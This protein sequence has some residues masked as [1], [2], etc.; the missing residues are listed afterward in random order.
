MVIAQAREPGREER[1]PKPK[2]EAELEAKLGAESSKKEMGVG[3]VLEPALAHSHPQ[4]SEVGRWGHVKGGWQAKH[5][6]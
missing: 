4:H 2:R 3:G 6:C 5:T 1:E